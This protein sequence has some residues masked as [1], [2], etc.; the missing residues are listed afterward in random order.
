MRTSPARIASGSMQSHRAA[1]DRSFYD[2]INFPPPGLAVI[3]SNGKLRRAQEESR[4]SDQ[5]DHA[6]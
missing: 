1:C 2:E 6:C 5:D 4:I 3:E